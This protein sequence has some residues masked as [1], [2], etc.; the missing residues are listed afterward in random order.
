[1][2]GATRAF[3]CKAAVFRLRKKL[4]PH[5]YPGPKCRPHVLGVAAQARH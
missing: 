2:H 4:V 1:M 3:P 5:W